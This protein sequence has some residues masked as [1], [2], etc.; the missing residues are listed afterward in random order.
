MWILSRNFIDTSTKDSILNTINTIANVADAKI[1]LLNLGANLVGTGLEAAKEIRG[2][3][4]YGYQPRPAYPRRYP[5][6]RRY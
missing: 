3:H 2:D 4:D 1:G 5:A 6:Y